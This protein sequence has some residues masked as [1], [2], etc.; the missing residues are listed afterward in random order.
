MNLQEMRHRTIGIAFTLLLSMTLLPPSLFAA[1]MSHREVLVKADQARGNA[2]GVEWEIDINSV[3]G[4][5]EQQRLIKVTARHFNSL[6]DFLAPSNVKG[7]KLL[8][9]DRNMWFIKPG[10]SKAVPISPRQKLIGGAANGDIA[11]TN[12]AG[13]Y[14]IGEASGRY[15]Q[16]GALLSLRP[17]GSRQKGHL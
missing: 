12:Y 9:I 5:R 14:K 11:S 1:E 7:Q 8:M 17:P 4:G 10:L 2:E 16:R 13:D 3:E 6:A 15:L